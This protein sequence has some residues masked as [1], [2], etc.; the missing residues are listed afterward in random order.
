MSFS[1]QEPWKP[2]EQQSFRAFHIPLTPSHIFLV[3]WGFPLSGLAG[4]GGVKREGGGKGMGNR[5]V[6]FQG[7]V[8]EERKKEENII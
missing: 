2:I 3:F 8:V 5:G 4:S 1:S 6:S 7:I